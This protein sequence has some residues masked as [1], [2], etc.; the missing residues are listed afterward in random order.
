MIRGTWLHAGTAY[1]DA[2]LK[3]VVDVDPDTAETAAFFTG[4]KETLKDRFD[5]LDIWIV[6][7]PIRII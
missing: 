7:I 1:E 2:L 5:Q 3:F 4:F 6:G